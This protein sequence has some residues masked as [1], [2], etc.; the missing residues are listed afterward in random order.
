[1]QKPSSRASLVYLPLVLLLSTG[2]AYYHLGVYLQ[3]V[4]EY[5]NATGVGGGYSF[6]DDFYPIWLTSREALLEH[7]NPYTPDMT[8][9]I[10]T[11]IFGHPLEARHPGDPLVNYRA[12]AY[13]AYV[14][15]LFWPLSFV[16]FPVVR[17]GLALAL[18]I[19]TA[20]SVP[21]WLKFLGL[22]ICA[23]QCAAVLMFVLSSY[24]VLEGLFA[25]QLGLVVG[26][27][28]AAAF[29]A[30]VR[31]RFF[32]AGTLLSFTFI[33]PQMSILVVAYL[34]VWSISN[35]RKRR[36]LVFGL[37]AWSALL[38]VASLIVWPHWISEWRKVLTGYG[39]YSTPPLITYSLGTR[40]GPKFG[41]ILIATLLIAALIVMWKMRAVA[42]PTR[43]FSLTIC[44]LLAL[45]SITILPGQAVHD[46]VMLLPGI[47]L[48]AWTW[49]ES[50]SNS[51]AL[52]VIVAA[53]ALALFWQWIMLVPLFVLKLILPAQ[54]FYT[55]A[56]LLLPF[57]AAASVPLAVAA[58]LGYMMGR[59]MRDGRIGDEA[60]G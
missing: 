37:L 38:G 45:T 48:I 21:L 50:F 4:M 56:V 20:L 7:R 19:L 32:L 46:H 28:L 60:P 16:R 6:G 14:D 52:K 9:A 11:G 53:G 22:R 42:A 26:F 54:R 47:F 18:T 31:D 51:R 1:M 30:L 36:A 5:R 2:M 41:P 33:K 59:T 34:V 44:L 13:P 3:H 25:G 17:V 12:F 40:L 29:A 35:W 49:R 8:R 15:L 57:H 23:H 24:A 10:Q 27:L 43:S 55:N 39:G 58:T